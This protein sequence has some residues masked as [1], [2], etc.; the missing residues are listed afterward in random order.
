MVI[1]PL[2]TGGAGRVGRLRKLVQQTECVNNAI[3]R[4]ISGDI[5]LFRADAVRGKA[6]ADCGDA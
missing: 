3:G 2:V 4:R 5:S 1:E 6:K